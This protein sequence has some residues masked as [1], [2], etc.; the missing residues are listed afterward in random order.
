MD[1][2]VNFYQNFS[3][4]C[5]LLLFLVSVFPLTIGSRSE[6]S[7]S[8][9]TTCTVDTNRHSC[10]HFMDAI[11]PDDFKSVFS[12]AVLN[13]AE[14]LRRL[15]TISIDTATE[16]RSISERKFG[17]RTEEAVIFLRLVMLKTA[18][19]VILAHNRFAKSSRSRGVSV[20]SLRQTGVLQICTKTFLPCKTVHMLSSTLV[21]T[22]ILSSP[23]LRK[24]GQSVMLLTSKILKL[25]FLIFFQSS[26]VPTCILILKYAQEGYERQVPYNISKRVSFPIEKVLK[27]GRPSWILP[28]CVRGIFRKPIYFLTTN[29]CLFQYWRYAAKD[30]LQETSEIILDQKIFHKRVPPRCVNSFQWWR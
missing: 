9:Q 30:S 23:R 8:S 12:S 25:L 18:V 13:F 1:F 4:I 22:V 21:H 26:S 6:K 11:G 27:H 5:Q 29:A 24:A 3:G 15:V 17:L 19:F 16:I 2:L 20:F 10:T 7:S 28:V 14:L